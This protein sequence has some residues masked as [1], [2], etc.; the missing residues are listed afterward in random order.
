M[1]ERRMFSRSVVASDRFLELPRNAQLLYFFLLLE[2]DDHGFVSG[3]KRILRTYGFKNK[4]ITVLEEAGFVHVFASGVVVI[5]HF[6]AQN[7][8]S[9]S[10]Q[11]ATEFPTEAAQ[12]ELVGGK[13]Y[14]L[15]NP[16]NF[17]TDS[18]QYSIG[19]YRNS[20][21]EGRGEEYNAAEPPAL[22]SY[23]NVQ[24]SEIE[25]LELRE[26]I[27]GIDD[28]IES[29][30]SYMQAT[31][32]TYADHAAALRRWADKDRQRAQ[33]KTAQNPAGNYSQRSEP[34]TGYTFA[35]DWGD[36]V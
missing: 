8:I 28:L 15:K 17:R 2:A 7:Q 26:E 16:E 34:Y 35:G 18:A 13:V 3:S 32:K 1:A 27:P 29:F 19:E 20:I 12:V 25:L 6:C 11:R 30:S 21:K 24:L 10:K 22:G 14:Q 36:V 9:P 33:D 23:R 5:M 31:G 4:D